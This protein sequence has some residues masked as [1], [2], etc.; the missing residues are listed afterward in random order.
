MADIHFIRHAHYIGHM[1]GYHAPDDAE[2]SSEGR[3]AAVAATGS[4][5]TVAVIVSSPLPRALQTA[6]LLAEHSGIPLLNVLPEL[7]EWRSPITVQGIPP[8]NFPED[9]AVWR[10]RRI[11][12]STSRYGDGESERELTERAERARGRLDVLVAENGPVLAVTHKMFLRALDL[13][14]VSVFHPNHWDEWTFL[15]L[16][17][18]DETRSKCQ[19]RNTWRTTHVPSPGSSGGTRN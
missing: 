6:E 1:P 4:L 2:L 19:R 15:E 8:A 9:Y 5:P 17:T 13:S 7:R 3:R 18:A 10:A 16:R 14:K 12:D 11:L